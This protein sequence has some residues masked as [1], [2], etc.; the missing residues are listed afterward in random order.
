[1]RGGEETPTYRVATVHRY[2]VDAF[3]LARAKVAALAALAHRVVVVRPARGAVPAA[4]D[5]LADLEA[6]LGRSDGDDI[7]DDLVAGD[8]TTESGRESAHER[9]G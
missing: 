2:A 3:V 1:V 4:T 9:Q 8:A 6:R 7:A 5:T